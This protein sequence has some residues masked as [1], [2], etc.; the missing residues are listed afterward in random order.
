MILMTTVYNEQQENRLSE[1]LFCLEKNYK[2]NLFEKIYI[3]YDTSKGQND[4]INNLISNNIFKVIYINQRPT[5]TD[6]FKIASKELD[7][8]EIVCICNTD[9]YFDKTINLVKKYCLD[10]K[11]IVLTKWTLFEDG[12]VERFQ[13]ERSGSGSADAWIFKNNIKKFNTDFKLGVARC[14]GR[15]SF[16]AMT[17]KIDVINPC[18]DIKTYHVHNTG[19]IN[20]LRGN[21]VYENES[22]ED[23]PYVSVLNSLKV[24]IAIPCI[25]NHFGYLTKAF[26]SI[27][28]G[29]LIPNQIAISIS[30]VITNDQKKE[31][32]EL[33]KKYTNYC[34]ITVGYN[35]KKMNTPITRESLSKILDGD[36][37]LYHDADDW[38][39]YQRVEIVKKIFMDYDIVH[40]CSSYQ[41]DYEGEYGN[42]DYDKIKK[43]DS[44]TLYR[45]YFVENNIPRAFGAP[46]MKTH[47]SSLS[48]KKEVL[49]KILW[50]G[51][52]H[53]KEDMQFCMNVLK[54]YNKSM[55]IDA[56]IFNYRVSF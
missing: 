23:I 55:I 27:I 52:E 11:F 10:N 46:F 44:N 18:L 21:L 38:Q 35:N 49:S 53:R 50:K 19:F 5:Y 25:W 9:I 8:D 12:R 17:N 33:C 56:P 20:E 26:D 28:N 40:L 2:S 45:E 6:F 7:K 43:I 29:T 54:Q 16:E 4:K 22:Y 41:F 34:K 24:S 13:K 32:F 42:I 31:I 14:D 51:L 37:I 3:L 30:P 36:I 15:L 47:A 48:I 1:Y 39:H